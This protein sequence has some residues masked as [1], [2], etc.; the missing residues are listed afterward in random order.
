[1]SFVERVA[2]QIRRRGKV[3]EKRQWPRGWHWYWSLG[4]V[5]EILKGRNYLWI[6]SQYWSVVSALSNP[7]RLVP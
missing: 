6:F 2:V 1:M 4:H 5:C 3:F 7:Q